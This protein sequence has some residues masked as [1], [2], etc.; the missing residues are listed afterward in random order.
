[1]PDVAFQALLGRLHAALRHKSLVL[2]QDELTGL[3]EQAH[4]IG[5]AHGK[6]VAAD[7]LSPSSEARGR[8]RPV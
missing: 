2:R 3:L 1:M 8:Q 7:E 4:A 6:I 5:V